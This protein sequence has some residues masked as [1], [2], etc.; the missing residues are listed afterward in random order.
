M[1]K[2]NTLQKGGKEGKNITQMTETEHSPEASS[3]CADKSYH[4]G[5]VPRWRRNRMGRPLFPTQ[6]HQKII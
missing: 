2:N 4:R 3:Y 5:A 6:I 1:I